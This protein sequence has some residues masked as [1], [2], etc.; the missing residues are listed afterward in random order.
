MTKPV[1]Q[2]VGHTARKVQEVTF[3]PKPGSLLE[4]QAHLASACKGSRPAPK[5]GR[6]GWDLVLRKRLSGRYEARRPELPAGRVSVAGADGGGPSGAGVG[7]NCFKASAQRRG[8]IILNLCSP[9][10]RLRWR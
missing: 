2:G 7:S 6:G 5:M 9:K 10:F 3:L 8:G 4:S 1:A